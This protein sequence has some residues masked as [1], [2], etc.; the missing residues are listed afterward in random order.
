MEVRSKIYFYDPQDREYMASV[1]EVASR[2]EGRSRIS[3][4]VEA[5]IVSPKFKGDAL[6]VIQDNILRRDGW[7]WSEVPLPPVRKGAIVQIDHGN[8]LLLQCR[9][10][11]LVKGAG[12]WRGDNFV[13]EGIKVA[14]NPNGST[15]YEGFSGHRFTAPVAEVRNI[16]KEGS[17]HRLLR[18]PYLPEPE[19]RALFATLYKAR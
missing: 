16:L 5:A 7:D 11:G 2:A 9:V 10:L 14:S 12:Y 4:R 8:G 3:T 17:G 18:G 6:M 19:K 13:Y 1:R 15:S